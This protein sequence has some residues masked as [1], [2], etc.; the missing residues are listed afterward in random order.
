M[1]VLGDG[2]GTSDNVHAMLSHGES[3]FTASTTS[4]YYPALSTIFDRKVSPQLANDLL[5]DLA[6]GSFNINP[7]YHTNT[8]TTLDYHKRGQIVKQAQSKVVINI[9]QK[10]FEHF[11]ENSKL[12][13]QN[14]FKKFM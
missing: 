12:I 3:V 9:D 8:S 7:E 1:K 14:F 2:S 4:D 10:G 6:I 5:T 11:K 13:S